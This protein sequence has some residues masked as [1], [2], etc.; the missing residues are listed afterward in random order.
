MDHIVVQ[1]GE[2]K[3][4]GENLKDGLNNTLR[5]CRDGSLAPC[6][7]SKSGYY[8]TYQE[9]KQISNESTNWKL[10]DSDDINKLWAAVDYNHR[11]LMSFK[12]GTNEFGLD[13]VQSGYFDENGFVNHFDTWIW[14][15]DLD[16]EASEKEPYLSFPGA[17]DD[18]EMGELDKKGYRLPVR[19]IW[20]DPNNH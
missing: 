17:A 11:N 13:I 9:A 3:W 20:T 18:I 7:R 12:R 19:L 15:F 10:P 5:I 4:L 8:Y 16:V 6:D 1:I 2:Q 14:R